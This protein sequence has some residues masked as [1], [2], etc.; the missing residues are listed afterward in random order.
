VIANAIDG[1][2]ES[3]RLERTSAELVALS[4]LG[5]DPV[6]IDLRAYFDGRTNE[7]AARLNCCQALWL[8][9]G[10]VFVLRHALAASGADALIVD[11]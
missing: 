10:N 9:G 4:A 6:E 8:R 1:E 7:L 2:A 5:L 3:V 11:L